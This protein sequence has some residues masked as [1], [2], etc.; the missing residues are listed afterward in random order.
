MRVLHLDSGREMRGGQIQL[1]TLVNALTK[2]GG[3]DQRILARGS[4]RDRLSA[5]PLSYA[6]LINAVRWADVIHAHD[7]RTH[8][9]AAPF[10]LGN[11]WRSLAAWPSPRSPAC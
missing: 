10:K 4:L 2:S 9:M 1:Q 11:R 5:E 7:A 8:Q 3:V 6:S